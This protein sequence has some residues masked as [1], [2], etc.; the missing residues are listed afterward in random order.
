MTTP[1]DR[2][3][4]RSLHPGAGRRGGRNLPRGRQVEPEALA[5]VQAVLGDRPRQRDLLIEFLHLLQDRYRCLHARHLAALAAEM[6]LALVEVYEVATFYAHFD[7]VLDG[8]EAPPPITVR[9]CDSLTCELMGARALLE[10]LPAKLGPGVRVVRAPCMGG[11]HNAPVTAIGH[12]L[13]EHATVEN[14]AAAVKRGETHPHLPDCRGFDAYVADGGYALLRDCL[15]GKRSLDSVLK[16]LEDSALK[17][18]G[19][20]GFPT[21]RK[22]RFVRAEPGPRLMAVN[23]DEGEPG[24]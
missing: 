22:W 18:L 3:T 9:V 24:T 16:A 20:A 2:Q 21:G 7:V 14:V 12:A 5:E 10:H 4:K 13:H 1:L 8:E 15:A 19:G 17:G 6:K 11:C 23:G